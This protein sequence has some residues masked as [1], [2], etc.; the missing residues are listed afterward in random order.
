[1]PSGREAEHVRVYLGLGSNLGDGPIQ[2]NEALS[3]LDRH[4]AIRLVRKSSYYSSAAW[5][6]EDQ[7]DFINAVAELD[8]SLSAAELLSVLLATE[9]KGGRKRS[10]VRWCPRVIDID[11]LLYGQDIVHQP[12]LE[13]PHPRMHLRA[14]VLLP[15]L[16]LVPNVEI[17]GVGLARVCLGALE[18]QRVQKIK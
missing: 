9:E 14:F 8:S 11:L 6:N 16:E 7:P 1:M 2:I 13:V 3:E 17:P 15:L 4:P 5:G 12:G 10:Q 18:K